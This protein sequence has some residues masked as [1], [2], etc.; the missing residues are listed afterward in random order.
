MFKNKSIVSKILK[1]NTPPHK[2][3]FVKSKLNGVQWDAD[4]T[5]II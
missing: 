5:V 1:E 3:Y 4:S 2:K